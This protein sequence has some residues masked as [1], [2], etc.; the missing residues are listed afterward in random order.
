[1]I[2]LIFSKGKKVQGI[3]LPLSFLF[4][5]TTSCYSAELRNDATL[6][7]LSGDLTQSEKIQV[8]I[9]RSQEETSRGLMY[10]RTMPDSQGMLFVFEGMT[11]RSFWMKNTYL[12]L[13][14]I[15]ID[16]SGKVVHIIPEVPPLSRTSRKSKFPCKYVLE[17]NAG[18]AKSA[19]ITIGSMMKSVPSD[20]LPLPK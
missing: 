20:A 9:A 6:Y 2:Q 8:Q 17:V 10:R 14:M 5:F 3:L 12:S 1:M 4:V 18:R 7:F 19:G 16:D 11:E 13:D 15:F